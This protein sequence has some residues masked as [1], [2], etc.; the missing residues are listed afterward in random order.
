[1]QSL[2]QLVGFGLSLAIA[3]MGLKEPETFKSKPPGVKA[4]DEKMISTKKLLQG[5]EQF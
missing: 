5:R 3:I 2:T 1:M 4:R